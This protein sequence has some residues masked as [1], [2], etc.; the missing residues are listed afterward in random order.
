MVWRACRT[1]SP[2]TAQVLTTTA[3]RTP[4]ASACAADHLELDDV[5]PAA[6]GDDVDAH[7]DAGLGEQRRIERALELELDRPGHQ[8]MVVALAPVDR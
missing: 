2:V 4:A 5:E 6:E 8:H 1:A 7:A 3:S